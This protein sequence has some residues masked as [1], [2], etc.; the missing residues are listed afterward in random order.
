[1]PRLESNGCV[2]EFSKN[3]RQHQA[4][5]KSFE[6][7]QQPSAQFLVGE[8]KAV[9]QAEAVEIQGQRQEFCQRQQQHNIKK[10]SQRVMLAGSVI[11]E[12]AQLA[13]PAGSQ[14]SD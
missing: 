6:F 13:A 2:Q 7:V 1:M 9:L 3:R 11:G 4:H 12:I 5:Q 10:D 8:L 14:Q